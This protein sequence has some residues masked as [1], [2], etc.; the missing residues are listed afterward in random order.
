MSVVKKLKIMTFSNDNLL[1]KLSERYDK[2][3]MWKNGR[4]GI[5]LKKTASTC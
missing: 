1:T 5:E 2:T 4:L 3:Q